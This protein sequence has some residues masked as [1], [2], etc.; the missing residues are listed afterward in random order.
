MTESGTRS[1]GVLGIGLVWFGA[2][3]SVA[4]ILTGS[5]IAP[6]G[7]GQGMLAIIVGHLIGGALM[8]AMSYIGGRFESPAMKSTAVSFGEKGAGIFAS[9]NV[10]QLVGWTAIMILMGATAASQLFTGVPF[11][12]WTIIIGALIALWLL[13]QVGGLTA[14][15][16]VAGAALFIL[17][18]IISGP[19]FV[20]VSEIAV[21]DPAAMTFGSAV[22]M[23]VAMPLSWLPLVADYTH[24]SKKPLASSLTATLVYGFASIWMFAIGL[25]GALQTGQMD[26]V[27]ILGASGLFVPAAIVV[28]L[29]TV[30]TTYL[31]AYSAGVSAEAI[32]PKLTARTFGVVV[33]AIGVV[34]ALTVADVTIMESFLYLIGSVFAPMVAV[35]ISDVF[36]IRKDS[37]GQRFDAVSLGVWVVGV[38]I[39]RILLPFMTPI[40]ITVPTILLVMVINVIVRA[41]VSRKEAPHA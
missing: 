31:D 11:W 7:F 19:L 35:L 40:G 29:S 6:L 13:V 27:A 22:E 38:I 10:I 3:V 1:F 41:I 21:V 9:L 8:F 37:R 18:I 14:L 26:V 34:I 33:T 23:S 30:T 20:G 36:L 16:A 39:Y 4:E 28:V 5:L 15:N 2:A 32:S 12:A 25:A 17:T 24:R